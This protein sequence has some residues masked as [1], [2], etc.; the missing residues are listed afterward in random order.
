M[1]F[2]GLSSADRDSWVEQRFGMDRHAVDGHASDHRA[3]VIVFQSR[4]P[5]KL[6]ILR[7]GE[8]LKLPY[9]D[10]AVYDRASGWMK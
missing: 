6:V 10:L 4:L 9:A 3:V 1:D 7:E 8:V 5:P 2:A